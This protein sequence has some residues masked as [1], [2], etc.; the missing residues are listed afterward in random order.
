MSKEIDYVFNE[1]KKHCWVKDFFEMLEGEGREIKISFFETVVGKKCNIKFLA[2]KEE[3]DDLAKFFGK[4]E[5]DEICVFYK[6]DPLLPPRKDGRV[7]GRI[8]FLKPSKKH[9]EML[10]E[11]RKS[12]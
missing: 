2:T 9:L 6:D 4:S 12:Q 1:I 3:I 11:D 8:R 5:N 7:E 10:E